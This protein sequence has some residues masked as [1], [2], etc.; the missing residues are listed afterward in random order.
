LKAKLSP[1]AL[2]GIGA[3]AAVLIAGFVV[4]FL[5]ASDPTAQAPIPYK[6]FDYGAHMQNQMSQY[7]RQQPG[8]GSAADASRPTAP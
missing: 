4:Y 3:A 8:T 2:L 6:K 7:N 5:R 1:K